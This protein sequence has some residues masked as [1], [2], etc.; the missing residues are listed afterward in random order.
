[1]PNTLGFGWDLLWFVVFIGVF[2]AAGWFL[3]EYYYDN[4][5]DKEAFKTLREVISNN[6]RITKGKEAKHKGG[7]KSEGAAL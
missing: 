7:D 2:G 5:D 1:M 3:G 4:P 6:K